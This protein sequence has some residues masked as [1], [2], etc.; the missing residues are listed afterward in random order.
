M[1][2]SLRRPEDHDELARLTRTTDNAKQRDRYRAIQ[3]AIEGEQTANIQ[4]AL[5]RSR[6]FVQRWCYTY[7]D[8][9]LDAIQPRKQTGRPTTLPPE[10]HEVFRQRVLDGPTVEDGVCTLR[11]T[12]IL[13]ILE[14]EFG[15]SYSL[16]GLY[17]LLARL[18]L[19]VLSPRP[20]HRKNDP[21]AM[22]QWVERAPFLSRISD[23]NTQKS[24][25]KS[26]SR[27]RRASA[28]RAR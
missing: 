14:R 16:S 12:D 25:S 20:V 7:R 23:I 19:V 24:A 27:T 3:L 22:G 11:G 5:A 18:H 4:R 6:G 10:Q 1:D 21:H 15:V 2:I 13:A 17:D 26:G 28:S 9:G 8:H